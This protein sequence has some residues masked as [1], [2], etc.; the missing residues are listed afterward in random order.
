MMG[1]TMAAFRHENRKRMDC[2]WPDLYKT[3]TA[4]ARISTTF[5]SPTLMTF[6][7]IAGLVIR[8]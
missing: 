8:L 3:P 2:A 7:E 1:K 4:G 6:A 5:L